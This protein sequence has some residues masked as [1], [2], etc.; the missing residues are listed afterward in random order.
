MMKKVRIHVVPIGYRLHHR[1]RLKALLHH[2]GLLRR[3]PTTTTFRT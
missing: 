1:T 3:R 2:P